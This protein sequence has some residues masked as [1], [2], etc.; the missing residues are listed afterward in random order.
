MNT[1]WNGDLPV[2]AYPENT[3]RITQKKIISY[4]VTIDPLEIIE[5]YGADALRMTLVTG[6][7]PGN[8]MNL[9]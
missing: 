5:Q 1:V 6:N 2:W 3:I 4:P 8:D 9:S 7:A